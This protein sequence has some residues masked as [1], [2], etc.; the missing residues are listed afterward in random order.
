ML[1]SM[2]LPPAASRTMDL[3]CYFERIGFDGTPTPTAST[4][5]ALA[6][7]HATSIPFENLAVIAHG[8]P[9]LDAAAVQD[10]LVTQRRGGYCY[11]QNTLLQQALV[12]IGFDVTGLSARV[13]YGL[14][15]E[16]PRPRSHMVLL[17]RLDDG[18]VL[19]DA[20]FGG[21]TL[22]AP[23]RL[24][25]DGEQATPHEPVR[26]VREQGD[27]LLQA[28]V[29][30]EWR[31]VYR[32]DL[33][34]QL[35]EDYVQQNWH[36]ATRPDALFANN[37]VV[38]RPGTGG[39]HTLFNRTLTWRPLGGEAERKVLADA[40]SLREVLHDVFGLC[41]PA[42]ELELAWDASGRGAVSSAM[43]SG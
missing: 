29:G 21:L 32:F 8:A 22:T 1:S 2:N 6:H 34:V 16:V 36:T 38:A 42:H 10:K 15:P 26:I 24:D 28:R 43:F 11:E 30:D 19:V 17:V 33:S 14:A 9:A 5:W 23:V 37:V 3:D 41:V 12:A 13:R 40:Q 31:D 35:A 25:V 39:R 27:F 7:R 18:P 4:L 20:G